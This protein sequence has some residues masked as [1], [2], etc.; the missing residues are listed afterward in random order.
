[1]LPPNSLQFFPY[2][3]VPACPP[4]NQ[5]TSEHKTLIVA[6]GVGNLF[7]FEKH[8][9]FAVRFPRDVVYM[10]LS[11]PLCSPMCPKY[12]SVLIVRPTSM[13]LDGCGNPDP[14]TSNPR[15]YSSHMSCSL[16]SLKG[17]IWGI[18]YGITIG[19]I[20]GDTRSLDY[21]S[22]DSSI[23]LMFRV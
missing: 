21:G 18:L 23:V 3:S 14:R 4:G 10:G 20:K 12:G 1:M 6:Q 22:Y 13:S 15:H 5:F 8:P 9:T 11:S 7:L 2:A 16:N 19:V 17:V